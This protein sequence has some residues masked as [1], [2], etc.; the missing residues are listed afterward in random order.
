VLKLQ[1]E[2][3]GLIFDNAV[4]MAYKAEEVYEY[5]DPV[6]FEFEQL[7]NEAGCHTVSLLSLSIW[8]RW[9]KLAFF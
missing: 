5:D 2:V 7:K 4:M 9:K 8:F 6:E 1:T 3:H